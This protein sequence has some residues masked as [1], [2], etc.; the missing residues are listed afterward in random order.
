M[1]A[2]GAKWIRYPCSPGSK[3]CI[4][5]IVISSRDCSA[6]AKAEVCYLGSIVARSKLKGIGGGALQRVI[7][8]GESNCRIKIWLNAGISEYLEILASIEN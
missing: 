3:P 8:C 2:R 6:E 5:N 7:A 4:L 1:K